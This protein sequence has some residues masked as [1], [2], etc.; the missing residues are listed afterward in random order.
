VQRTICPEGFFS[1]NRECHPCPTGSF[2]PR[3]GTDWC[4]LCPPGTYQDQSGQVSCVLCGEKTYQNETGSSECQQCPPDGYED[5]CLE[6]DQRVVSQTYTS[7]FYSKI[8]C[9]QSTNEYLYS[10][11][12]Y[13]TYLSSENGTECICEC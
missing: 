7:S 1:N 5:H 9:E 13:S 10:R 8:T 3:N 11:Y 12:S 4:D 2:Q 6:R